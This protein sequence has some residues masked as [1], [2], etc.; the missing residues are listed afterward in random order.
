MSW[1]GFWRGVQFVG[2][3]AEAAGGVIVA[4]GGSVL[5]A[6]VGSPV[7]I[8]GG[9]ALAAH[10]VDQMVAAWHGTESYAS[11]IGGSI[12]ETALGSD[13]KWIGQVL[14]DIGPGVGGIAKG[15]KSMPQLIS[16]LRGMK[17]DTLK[18]F[19]G[20]LRKNPARMKQVLS[21]LSDDE[22]KKMLKN[23]EISE[24]DLIQAGLDPS[25]YT[26]GAKTT[27]SPPKKAD[28]HKGGLPSAKSYPS[29]DEA[30]KAAL[31][32]ANPT[33]ISEN[34]E[35]GGLI[36][37]NP[38]GTYGYSTPYKGTP[39]GFDPNKVSAPNGSTVVGDY[40]THGD[41][42]VSGPGDVPIR[43]SNPQL[44]GYNS[45]NFSGGPQTPRDG[46]IEFIT[47]DAKGKPEYAGYLGTPSG[48]FKKFDP[49]T[50]QVS[51]IHKNKKNLI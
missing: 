35:Y 15:I 23:G 9:G 43:T 31:N 26:D 34:V 3:A 49:K 6:G 28:T 13:Y 44:D 20:Q 47:Q 50:G 11:Q 45:D 37:K 19:I 25:K 36:Y 7:A 1:D 5:T 4:A 16:K 38:D 12:A 8:A 27:K 39:K 29:A 40:H 32:E 30:A 41:Y 17:G 46:D 22:I 14:G 51:T 10:G 18:D 21:E 48:D 2:G 33:S 24:G 42:S